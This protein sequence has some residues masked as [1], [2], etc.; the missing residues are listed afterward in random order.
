MKELFPGMIL[1][2][3]LL[4]KL[5]AVPAFLGNIFLQENHIQDLDEENLP[6]KEFSS[7]TK[8]FQNNSN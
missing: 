5:C 6:A 4:L 7:V 2:R 1:P 3:N 8:I